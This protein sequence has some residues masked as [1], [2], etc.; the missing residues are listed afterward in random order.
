MFLSKAVKFCP[1]VTSIDG[2]SSAQWNP[3]KIDWWKCP[4]LRGFLVSL[5]TQTAWVPVKFDIC[6]SVLISYQDGWLWY[7]GTCYKCTISRNSL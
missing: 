5:N 2:F 3:S 1:K 6:F 7:S 4:Y